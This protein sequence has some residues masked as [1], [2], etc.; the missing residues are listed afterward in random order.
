MK[1]CQRWAAAVQFVRRHHPCRHRDAKR[2]NF[3][4]IRVEHDGSRVSSCPGKR[5][6]IIPT[7]ARNVGEFVLVEVVEGRNS[8]MVS[9]N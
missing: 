4:R 3:K 2:I 8:D 5:A 9:I 1:A 7:T 6:A